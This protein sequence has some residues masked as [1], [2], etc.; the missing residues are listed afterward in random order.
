MRPP[1]RL[2]RTGRRLARTGLATR[3]YLVVLVLSSFIVSRW[4]RTGTFIAT[5]DMG[6]FIRRGWEQEFLWSWNHQ[7]TGAGSAAYTLVRAFEFVLIWGC[8]AVGLGEHTAQWLF[9]TCIYGLVGVG[10]AYCASAFVRS[11]P[12]I[13]V[14]GAFGVLN[15]FFLTRLPNPLNII[16]V[17]S[18]AL[19]TGLAIRIAQG[20]RIPTPVAGF[21]LLPTSFLAFNPPM[22]VVAYAWTIGGA[23]LLALLILG[24]RQALRLLWWYVRAAPW[25]VLLNAWWVVPLAQSFTGGGAQVNATFT[26]PS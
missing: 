14:A 8:Q 5:G 25:A 9:Y 18:V 13:V 6:P 17:G 2:T 19:L 3:P 12:A 10:V 24:R 21:A 23:P 4:F 16:S 15:G 1:E 26:D 22:L 11:E 20:R 7:T